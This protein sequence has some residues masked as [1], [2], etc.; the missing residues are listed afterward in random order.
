M[1]LNKTHTNNI[2]GGG[3]GD[4][5][6]AGKYVDAVNGIASDP[7]SVPGTGGLTNDSEIIQHRVSNILTSSTRLAINTQKPTIR[8][9]VTLRKKLSF[10]DTSHKD[11]N[12]RRGSKSANKFRPPGVQIH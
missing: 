11:P 3:G 9:S 1:P 8:P 6:T 12:A 2:P 5:S 4:S 7:S 10:D